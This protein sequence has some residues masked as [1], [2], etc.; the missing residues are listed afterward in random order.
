[1]H[2]VEQDQRKVLRSHLLLLRPEPRLG[3]LGHGSWVISP[4]ETSLPG[5]DPIIDSHTT[6]L[7]L[8]RSPA[9][10]MRYIFMFVPDWWSRIEEAVVRVVNGWLLS[11]KAHAIFGPTCIRLCSP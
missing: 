2:G 3:G 6:P 9:G 5:P 8:Y 1:M 7:S 4:P 10:I 11:M